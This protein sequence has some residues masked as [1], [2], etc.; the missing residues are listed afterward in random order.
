[1][2]AACSKG[3]PSFALNERLLDHRFYVVKDL[4]CL[5]GRLNTIDVNPAISVQGDIALTVDESRHSE[6]FSTFASIVKNP[7]QHLH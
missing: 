7:A 3:A 6:L 1:M 5:F 4:N 2:L